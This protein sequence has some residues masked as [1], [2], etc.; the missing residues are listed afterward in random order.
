MTSLLTPNTDNDG[1]DGDGDGDGDD[2]GNTLGPH[3]EW[4]VENI[5]SAADFASD[6]ASLM[7]VRSHVYCC[8]LFFVCA[9]CLFILLLFVQQQHSVRTYTHKYTPT[10]LS[11][12]TRTR[13]HCRHMSSTTS[14]SLRS[15][16]VL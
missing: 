7:Q 14:R 10:Y 2:D 13:T 16:S 6:E 15:S 3:A 9:V 1:G 4:S 5:D 12:Y 8:F 11:T